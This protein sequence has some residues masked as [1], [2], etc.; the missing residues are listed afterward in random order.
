[1]AREWLFLN[2]NPFFSSN[3]CSR[4]LLNGLENLCSLQFDHAHAMKKV[5]LT[6]WL[7]ELNLLGLTK[8]RK[9]FCNIYRRTAI[10][11]N[12]S[13]ELTFII[14][15]FGGNSQMFVS[16][17]L[18]GKK[19]CWTKY[20]NFYPKRIFFSFSKTLLEVSTFGKTTAATFKYFQIT[21]K[22]L[23]NKNS[24]QLVNQIT[25]RLSRMLPI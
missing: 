13:P 4:K 3:L 15:I 11:R 2:N 6:I 14:N 5:R 7:I 21:K 19:Q 8:K 24:F 10:K 1:M 18:I 20:S 22:Q 9:A 17:L 16:N 12:F 25:E 23:K